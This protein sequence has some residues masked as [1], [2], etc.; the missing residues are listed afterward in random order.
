MSELRCEWT[1]KPLSECP[2]C[3]DLDDFELDWDEDE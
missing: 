3:Q 1:D 2:H